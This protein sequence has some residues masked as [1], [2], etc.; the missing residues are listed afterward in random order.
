[1][2]NYGT[3]NLAHPRLYW[4]WIKFGEVMDSELPDSVFPLYYHT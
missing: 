3:C 1:M 4:Q 2:L